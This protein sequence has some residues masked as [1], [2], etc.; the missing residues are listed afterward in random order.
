MLS[1][2]TI[3]RGETQACT[4]CPENQGRGCGVGQGN[5]G[6]E[7]LRKVSQRSHLSWNWKGRFASPRKDPGVRNTR[8]TREHRSS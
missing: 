2:F 8:G 7:R 4:K 3:L 5:G 1:F 6:V